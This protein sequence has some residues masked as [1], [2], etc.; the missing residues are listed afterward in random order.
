MQGLQRP[1]FKRR[2]SDV[3]YGRASY[4]KQRESSN[5]SG[6]TNSDENDENLDTDRHIN[7]ESVTKKHGSNNEEEED[8]IIDD[9]DVEDDNVYNTVRSNYKSNE[10]N[11]GNNECNTT[12][13]V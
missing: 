10:D 13:I 12:S 8:N 1:L 5:E 9:D 7:V 3:M 2:N 4:L 11:I 6:T